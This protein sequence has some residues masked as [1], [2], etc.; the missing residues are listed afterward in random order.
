MACG[1]KIVNGCEFCFMGL[2]H[3]LIPTGFVQSVCWIALVYYLILNQPC[4]H[5]VNFFLLWDL[6]S[7][8]CEG[9]WIDSP[10][11]LR[12]PQT[13]STPLSSFPSLPFPFYL[14]LPHCHYVA[15]C[16]SISRFIAEVVSS[17]LSLFST[18]RSVGWDQFIFK[19]LIEL[20]GDRR[21][22]FRGIL[23]IRNRSF[24]VLTGLFTLPSSYWLCYS[25]TYFWSN[26]P[27]L[28]PGHMYRVSEAFLVVFLMPEGFLEF[29]GLS[30]F[31]RDLFI[32]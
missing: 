26:L 24:L 19:N 25:H 30:S 17:L 16:N 6:F 4:T 14:I 9:I 15:C 29:H 1:K 21:I 10:S 31:P 23:K 22:L 11:S 27:T 18:K 28:S 5:F 2:L 12:H 8:I 13:S 3:Q 32:S 7:N 20:T